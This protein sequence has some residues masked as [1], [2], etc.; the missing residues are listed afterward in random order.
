MKQMILVSLLANVVVLIPVCLS[1]L[2]DASWVGAA[3]GANSPARGILLSLYGAILLVSIG[4]FFQ[5][6]PLFV[7]PLLLAVSYTHLTLPTILRV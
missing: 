1:L 4:L 6:E 2:V 3:Y 7:A 5:R